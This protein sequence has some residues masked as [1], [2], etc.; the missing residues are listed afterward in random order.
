MYVLHIYQYRGITV[1]LAVEEVLE[2]Y[3][4]FVEDRRASKTVEAFFVKYSAYLITVGAK[5]DTVLYEVETQKD[6]RQCSTK[7]T[8]N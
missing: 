7:R 8:R 4:F 6:A 5:S 3:L 2:M 1:L